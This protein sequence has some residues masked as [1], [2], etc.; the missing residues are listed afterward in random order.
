MRGEGAA[1]ALGVGF[2]SDEA[3]S[4]IPCGSPAAAK[5]SEFRV[6]SASE[7]A[8][9]G[10]ALR[11]ELA[12]EAG[13]WGELALDLRDGFSVGFSKLGVVGVL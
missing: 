9:S 4:E 13:L 8:T 1:E 7:A 12:L 6:G 3:R 2:G 11:G 10:E 5:S